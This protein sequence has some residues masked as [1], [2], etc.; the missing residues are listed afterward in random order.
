MFL[1]VCIDPYKQMFFCT[2]YLG[3]VLVCVHLFTVLPSVRLS[4]SDLCVILVLV[5]TYLGIVGSNV[6]LITT[7]LVIYITNKNARI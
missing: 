5:F 1:N 3:L 2:T 4:V 6:V 7:L